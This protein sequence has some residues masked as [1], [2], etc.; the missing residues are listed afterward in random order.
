MLVQKDLLLKSKEQNLASV[1]FDSILDLFKFDSSSL[2]RD[3]KEKF[4]FY[5]NKEEGRDKY[6]DWL[7]PT[8]KNHG[9]IVD[10]ALL[11]DDEL[12]KIL[13][14]MIAQF[15]NS[16]GAN[17]VDY[18]QQIEKSKRKRVFKDN[19]DELDVDRYF[20]HEFETMWQST[21]RIEVDARH[22]LITL[23][24][25]I[26]NTADVNCEESFWK[27]C[28]AVRLM[29]E[30]EQAGKQVK[31]V[32]GSGTDYLYRHDTTKKFTGSIT[33]KNYN[34]RLSI[35]RLAAMSHV[36][37]HRVFGFAVKCVSDDRPHLRGMGASAN[38]CDKLIPLHVQKDVASGHTRFVYIPN[39]TNLKRAQMALEDCYKQLED[40]AKAA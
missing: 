34:E 29:K 6:G 31:V 35:E 18:R 17:T 21:K 39:V 38:V 11:G 15:D 28:V 37:F 40:L 12:L 20:N 26:G 33:V 14:P 23:F 9:D 24:I 16:I 1:H 3:G 2:S 22:R 7:G 25:N 13:D 10:H 8:N 5:M 30:L 27:T 19:G 36:G 32:V 4:D